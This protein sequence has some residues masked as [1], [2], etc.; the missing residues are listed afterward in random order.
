MDEA[1]S[2][3]ERIMPIQSLILFYMTLVEDQ[4]E[5]MYYG[6]IVKPGDA[7]LVLMR[8]KTGENEYRVIFGD[9]HAATVN[10]EALAT[11]EATLP[12]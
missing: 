12:R 8:W 3:M 2:Q 5:P 9:L 4:K 7:A 1:R 10:A 6:K 11:L